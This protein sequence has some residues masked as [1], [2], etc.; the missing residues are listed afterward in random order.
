MLGKYS[1]GKLDL[2]Q[3]EMH[4]GMRGPMVVFTLHLV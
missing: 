3:E 2:L 1:T 4:M